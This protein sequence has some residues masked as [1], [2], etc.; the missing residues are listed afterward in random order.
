V[1]LKRSHKEIEKNLANFNSLPK[2]E[3]QCNP[4]NKA[5]NGISPK[6]PGLQPRTPKTG[7]GPPSYK[8]ESLRFPALNMEELKCI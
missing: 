3:R 2:K 1:N 6:D 8:M 4:V 5:D 7:F